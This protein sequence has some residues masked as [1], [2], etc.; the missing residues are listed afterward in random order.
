MTNKE[1]AL[2]A[3][4]S[5]MHLRTPQAEALKAFHEVINSCIS[6]LAEMTPDEM[7]N[8]FRNYYPEWNYGSGSTEFTFHLA[9]GV[10]KTRLIGAVMAYLFLAGES[11]NYLIISPRAEIIRKFLS[12]C[13]PTS[14]DYIFVDKNFVGL[15]HIMDSESIAFGGTILDSMYTGPRIWILTPQ[16]LTA[17][18]AKLKR[19]SEYDVCST[20]DYIRSQDDLVVFFD[21]S[22]R[23]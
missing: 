1:Q 4:L 23:L 18:D 10:G 13:Q 14:D 2:S 17:K 6:P 19:R 8:L 3:V 20:V 9:T 15:P 16:A 5:R 12:V 21:E 22:S 11:K 7:D